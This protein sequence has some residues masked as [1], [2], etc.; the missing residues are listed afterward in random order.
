MTHEQILKASI[1][2]A[3]NPQLVIVN[4]GAPVPI[5]YIDKSG[6]KVEYDSSSTLIFSHEFAKAFWGDDQWNFGWM[7]TFDHNNSYSWWKDKDPNVNMEYHAGSEIKMW[8]PAWQY[9]LQQM[10][11]EEDPITYLEKF[12]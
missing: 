4:F 1:E 9:H 7:V 11:L 10:V 5:A 12:L 3:F 2:K 6:M 8:L